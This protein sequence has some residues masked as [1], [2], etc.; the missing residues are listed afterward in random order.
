MMYI[1]QYVRVLLL[2]VEPGLFQGTDRTDPI[3]RDQRESTVSGVGF[4]GGSGG[5]A[6]LLKGSDWVPSEQ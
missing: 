3:S 2:L 5:T 6:R 4:G 1:P